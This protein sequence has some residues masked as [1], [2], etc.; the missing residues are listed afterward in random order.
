MPPTSAVGIAS[1]L[2]EQIASGRLA[3]G[4]PLPT[5]LELAT[6][7]RVSRDTI[8]AAVEALVTEG[9]VESRRPVGMFVRERHLYPYRPQGDDGVRPSARLGQ[10]LKQLA[11]SAG[12]PVAGDVSASVVLCPPAIA[13]HLEVTAADA[14]LL[15][16]EVLSIDGEPHRSSTAYYPVTLFGGLS[17]ADLLLP[18]AEAR[19]AAI[20]ARVDRSVDWWS[21]RM[22]TPEER[23]LLRLPR[24]GVPVA[25]NVCVGYS[26]DGEALS[27]TVNVLPG[28]RH[29]AVYER[30]STRR[31]P[32]RVVAGSEGCD[33]GQQGGVS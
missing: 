11:A 17:P 21:V 22:P 30:R 33:G 5:Q 29:V 2:R 8:R 18:D 15:R 16:S 13:E 12:T 14:V 9:L 6:K 4:D 24:I 31:A 20:A 25:V 32:G 10:Y 7:Y 27:C 26:P 1:D 3:Q 19:L 23:L 28:D